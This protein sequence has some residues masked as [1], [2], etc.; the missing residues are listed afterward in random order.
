MA[1]K[2]AAKG[3]R[4]A[5]LQGRSP[6]RQMIE[7]LAWDLTVGAGRDH[8][9]VDYAQLNEEVAEGHGRAATPAEQACFEEAW[10]RCLQDMAQP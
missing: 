5:R 9:S 3:T 8:E 7:G 6:I 4:A 1:S 10:R 2:A